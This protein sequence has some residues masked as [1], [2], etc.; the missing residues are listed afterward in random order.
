MKYAYSTD[1]ER[2]HGEFDTPQQAAD[3]AFAMGDYDVVF[4]AEIKTPVDPWDCIDGSDVIEEAQCHE[5]YASEFAEDWPG[6]SSE[7]RDELT[8]AIRKVFRE[9]IEKHQLMPWHFKCENPVKFYRP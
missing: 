4:V 8:E 3:E 5:D 2:Y 7:Q 1:E 9:W 6:E